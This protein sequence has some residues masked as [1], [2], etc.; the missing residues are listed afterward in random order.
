MTGA[1]SAVRDRLDG[2]EQL[3]LL[4]RI[5]RLLEIVSHRDQLRFAEGRAVHQHPRGSSRRSYAHRHREVGITCD[6]RSC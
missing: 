1:K 3:R 2:A 6:R 5:E 4:P